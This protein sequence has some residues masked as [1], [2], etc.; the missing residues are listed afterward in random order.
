MTAAGHASLARRLQ[1]GCSRTCLLI[2]R[3]VK[4]RPG[5]LRP[6]LK[7]SLSRCCQAWLQKALAPDGPAVGA[8]AAGC[9]LPRLASEEAAHGRALRTGDAGRERRRVHTERSIVDLSVR[10]TGAYGFGHACCQGAKLAPVPAGRRQSHLSMPGDVGYGLSPGTSNASHTAQQRHPCGAFALSWA[11]QA[12]CLQFSVAE[13]PSCC[14][15]DT[16][17]NEKSPWLGKAPAARGPTR[18]RT[19]TKARGHQPPHACSTAAPRPTPGTQ[20]ESQAPPPLRQQWQACP[21]TLTAPHLAA[22]AALVGSQSHAT[23]CRPLSRP[24]PRRAQEARLHRGRCP[25]RRAARAPLTW[26]PQPWPP[27]PPPQ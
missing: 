13:H 23:P 11:S 14:C 24:Q 27:H 18:S 15:A 5:L 2:W 25:G 22:A 10:G 7:N 20:K 4:D 3:L 6:W 17:G 1:G 26:R 21:S 9:A 8:K 16:N 19:N 12:T